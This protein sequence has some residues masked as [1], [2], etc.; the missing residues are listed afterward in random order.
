MIDTGA[1][2]LGKADRKT[3]HTA[4]AKLSL[5]FVEEGMSSLQ[6]LFYV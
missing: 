5:V 4:V 1:T 3:F 2:K 6:N